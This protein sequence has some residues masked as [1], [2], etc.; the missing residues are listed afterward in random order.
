MAKEVNLYKIPEILEKAKILDDSVLDAYND[1][2]QSFN[3]KARET[4]GKFR[5]SNGDLTNSNPFMLIHL[6]NAGLLPQGARLAIQNN[7]EMGISNDNTFLS[8]NYT[9][10][11]YV[12]RTD[13]DS[14]KPND[15]LAKRLTTQLKNKGIKLGEGVLIPFLTLGNENN[16][17]SEYGLIHNLNERATKE[18]IRDVN[19]F[20][21]NYTKKDGLVRA[22][23]CRNWGWG[24]VNGD[25]AYSDDS[26]RVVIV[27]G[28]VTS[29]NFEE[30]FAQ[31]QELVK[32]AK[33]KYFTNIQLI[34]D[35]LDNE[36]KG[37]NLN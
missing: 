1:S 30:M 32:E 33:Q 9:D 12:L 35:Q 37:K 8:G 4:L 16:V 11:G 6:Q 2:I 25:L 28:G 17:D 26:G 19:E 29:Q 18:T 21:W 14:Y 13:G 7:L 31:K 22:H 34:R 23:L 15:L 3:P 36:L 5:K 24:S 10:F 20:K 27:S